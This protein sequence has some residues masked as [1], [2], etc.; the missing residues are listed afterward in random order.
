ML[1][2]LD[3][4]HWNSLSACYSTPHAL[5]ALREI[6]ATRRLGPA[7]DRLQGEIQHQGSVYGVTSAVLP[8][9]IRLA[10]SLNP[11]EQRDLWI[12]VGFLVTAGADSFGGNEPVPGMQETLTQ[13]LRDAEPLA[14]QAFLDAKELDLEEASYFA[15]ACVALAGHPIGDTLWEFLS[16]GEGYVTLQCTDCEAECEVDGFTD[17]LRAPCDPPPVP[18]L[19]PRARP[20]WARVPIDLLPGFDAAARAVADAGLPFNAPM[21]AVWCLVAAMV[22]AKGAV[23]WARTLLRLTGHFRCGECQS[24]LPIAALLSKG[25]TWPADDP[26]PPQDI[27]P[28][29]IA[30]A[31]GFK[32]APGG[33][34]VP[35]DFPLRPLAVPDGLRPPAATE[36]LIVMPAG[37]IKARWMPGAPTVPWLPGV[38]LKVPWLAGIRDGRTVLAVGDAAGAVRL[39]DPATRKPYGTLFE[40]PGRPVMG[41]AFAQALLRHLVIA[42]GDLTVDVWGPDAADGER[43]SM[44]PA[45]DSLR[46]NG[47]SRIVAVCLGTD[48]GFRNPVLLADRDGTVSMW[49]PFGVRLSDPL[50]P[51]PAHYDVVAVAASAGLVVT[52]GRASR[53]LR[54]WQPAS[55]KVSLV[56][57]AFAPEW[58]TFTGTTLTAGHADG[59]VSFSVGAEA[60]PT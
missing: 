59:A 56:P 18:S 4:P 38:P 55:G 19:M 30:D 27:D 17:P 16:P 25:R 43:S 15:L 46:A 40:R 39:C 26:G 28:A 44:A 57:L 14:L 6:V 58:L 5:E 11:D 31:A 49:E 34:L 22:A 24:V 51:D 23:P 37:G 21:R 9:L 8:H 53:N 47:H 52:A 32:P 1:L 10:P 54:I 7:W 50:L 29:A 35:G 42:Y 33:T 36:A 60:G 2:P 41:M 48:L 3:S 20:E 45:P 12:E 13:S